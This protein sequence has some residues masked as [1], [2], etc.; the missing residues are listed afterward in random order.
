MITKLPRLVGF[1]SDGRAVAAGCCVHTSNG[2]VSR[3]VLFL[4][5]DGPEFIIQDVRGKTEEEI[6]DDATAIIEEALCTPSGR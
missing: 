4:A 6:N 2:I 3:K 5:S 1:G